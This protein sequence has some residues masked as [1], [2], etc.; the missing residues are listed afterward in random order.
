MYIY[1][2]FIGTFKHTHVCITGYTYI[3]NET[4]NL[5]FTQARCSW[6]NWPF[7]VRS[8]I[9]NYASSWGSLDWK[10]FM[11]SM[12]FGVRLV[13]K[14]FWPKKT[15][16]KTYLEASWD[17]LGGFFFVVHVICR[18]SSYANFNV[19]FWISHT[20]FRSLGY[21]AQTSFLRPFL[22][23]LVFWSAKTTCYGCHEPCAE[24]IQTKG[25]KIDCSHGMR[26]QKGNFGLSVGVMCL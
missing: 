17:H 8:G 26:L 7:A 18:I 10:Y 11:F 14:V 4:T 23:G 12:F 6:R 15:C 9:S 5:F 21:A 25:A 1:N 2:A 3:S 16:A 24:D 19:C 13:L 22:L 20:G